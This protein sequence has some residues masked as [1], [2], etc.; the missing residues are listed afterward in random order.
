MGTINKLSPASHPTLVLGLAMWLSLP[1]Q[2]VA[3]MTQRVK[4][5]L[6]TGAWSLAAPRTLP[7]CEQ[8][9]KGLQ[10]GS[11]GGPANSWPSSADTEKS[12]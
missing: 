10:G 5:Y 7:L 8:V 3:N 4:K 2:R 11:R 12:H 9:C 1:D 6:H